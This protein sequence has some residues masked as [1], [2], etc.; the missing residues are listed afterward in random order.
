MKFYLLWAEGATKERH[1]YLV[2]MDASNGVR[3]SALHPWGYYVNEAWIY[4]AIKFGYT[5]PASD[6]IDW[7]H[8]EITQEQ[9]QESLT[10]R[11]ANGGKL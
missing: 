10:K 2:Q 9:Y 6:C 4:S 8:E 11:Q 1:S 5:G 3:L 7:K